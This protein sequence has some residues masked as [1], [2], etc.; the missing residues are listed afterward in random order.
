MGGLW[1]PILSGAGQATPLAFVRDDAVEETTGGELVERGLRAAASLRAQGVERGTRVALILLNTPEAVAAL[2]GVWF[3]GGTAVSLPTPARG[4]DPDEYV[5]QLGALC[6]R[7]GAELLLSD[8]MVSGAVGA[9]LEGAVRVHDWAGLDR[10][11]ALAPEPA[12]EDEVVFVQCSSG[13]T[14]IPKACMLT[15]RAIAAHNEIIEQLLGGGD[16]AGHRVASW[17]PMSHDM[18]LFGGVVW[19]L[20]RGVPVLLGP[21]ERFALAPLTWFEDVASWEATITAGPP[22]A[23]GLALRHVRRRGTSAR[24]DSLVCCFVAAER[25]EWSTLASARDMLAPNGLRFEALSP[26]YGLAEATAGV[27]AIGRD[28]CPSSIAV[29]ARR[30][31]DRELEEVAPGSDGAVEVVCVGRPPSGVT[32]RTVEPEGI[33]EIV[34]SA[35]SL[36]SGYCG[37]P[38]LT[39][40]RFRDGELHTGDLGFMRDGR[41]YVVGRE[42]DVLSIAGRKVYARDVEAEI[43]ALDG[44]RRGGCAIVDVPS[45]RETRLVL[46]LELAGDGADPP[47]L[48]ANAARVAA[49][50]AGMPI[51]EC[52]L[53]ERGA[54]PKTPTGKLQRFRCRQLVQGDDIPAVARVRLR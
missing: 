13:S 24:L 46:M 12:P 39:A 29:D 34:L 15:A 40:R 35:P 50:R 45:E 48:A 30:L 17:M 52:I 54:L 37:D 44:A 25:I 47:V 51:H 33:S 10:A 20:V 23:L 9:G 53:L 11:A 27:T 7:V 6:R 31:A 5:S 1:E 36:A 43:A 18:G 26:G 14:R 49:R 42:D 38:E 19:P 3:A 2:L 8:A 4:M 28:E 41:L 32:M 16:P 22:S 21:P